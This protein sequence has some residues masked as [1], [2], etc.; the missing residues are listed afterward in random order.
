MSMERRVTARGCGGVGTVVDDRLD[1][2]YAKCGTARDCCE[3]VH[4]YTHR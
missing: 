3:C 2:I 4:V 1:V